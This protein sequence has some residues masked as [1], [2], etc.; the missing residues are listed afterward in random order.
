MHGSILLLVMMPA[1]D[2]TP[3]IIQPRAGDTLV[4]NQ[5]CW[6]DTA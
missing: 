3:L 2:Q 4:C 5:A 1:A 6:T